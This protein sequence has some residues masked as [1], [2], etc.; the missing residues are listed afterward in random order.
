VARFSCL[1]RLEP[2]KTFALPFQR[3]GAAKRNFK[4]GEPSLPTKPP[5][6]R[7][8]ISRRSS[9]ACGAALLPRRL[10]SRSPDAGLPTGTSSPR[11]KSAA[12][13][14]GAFPPAAVRHTE[15]GMGRT[16]VVAAAGGNF[17]RN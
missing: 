3:L 14:R 15:R 6:S 11:A 5:E 16:R 8:S 13:F 17:W 2:K 7:R 10:V 4:N 1:A 12:S 9:T